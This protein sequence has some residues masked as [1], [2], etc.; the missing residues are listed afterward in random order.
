MLE[1]LGVEPNV[2]GINL[3]PGKP[4]WFGR[5]PSGCLVFGLP[6]DPVS[7]LTTGRIF[8]GAAVTLCPLTLDHEVV[9]GKNSRRRRW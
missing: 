9:Q 2:H 3:Q 4:L 8:A 7:S 5:A 6:G 1:E